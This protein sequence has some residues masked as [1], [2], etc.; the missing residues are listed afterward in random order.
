MP[1]TLNQVFNTTSGLL[2]IPDTMYKGNT[3]KDMEGKQA[4]DLS[5]PID[6]IH[7]TALINTFIP[8]MPILK[9]IYKSTKKN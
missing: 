2:I 3:V 1:S 5:L 6:F 7:T 4:Q 8:T 9:S